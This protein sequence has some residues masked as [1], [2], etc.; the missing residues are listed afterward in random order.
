[1]V[2]NTL[3]PSPPN[4][5]TCQADGSTWVD[6]EVRA[7]TSFTLVSGTAGSGV[8]AATVRVVYVGESG[9]RTATLAEWQGPDA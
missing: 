9:E 2:P 5:V 1:M 3:A 4:S 6:S 8:G 7:G